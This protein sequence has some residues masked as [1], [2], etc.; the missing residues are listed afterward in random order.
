MLERSSVS[1]HTDDFHRHFFLI[2][3]LLYNTSRYV[4][5]I[6]RAIS[7]SED[8]RGVNSGPPLDDDFTVEGRYNTRRACDS[9][10][11]EDNNV[12][13][14]KKTTNLSLSFFWSTEATRC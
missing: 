7:G 10:F 13:K 9:T 6:P 8:V 3:H 1:L 2:R 14:E 5:T 12:D 4:W 11:P